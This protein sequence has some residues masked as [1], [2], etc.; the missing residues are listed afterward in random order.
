[1]LSRCGLIHDD[2]VAFLFERNLLVDEVQAAEI[3]TEVMKSPP[4]VGYLT[5]SNAYPW[6][7]QYGRAIKKA[8]EVDGIIRIR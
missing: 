7:L 6:R 4:G 2:I 3:A 8:G 1:L 5:V